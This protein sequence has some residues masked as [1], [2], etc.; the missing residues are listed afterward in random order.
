MPRKPNM[1][2]GLGTLALRPRMLLSLEPWHAPGPLQA[3]LLSGLY[4]IRGFDCAHALACHVSEEP[5]PL[6][7]PRCRCRHHLGSKPVLRSCPLAAARSRNGS[8]SLHFR[9]LGSK[10]ANK[11]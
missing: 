1:L 9:Q 11:P 2:R 7:L 4:D 3:F 6:P 10:S 5:V 8:Q